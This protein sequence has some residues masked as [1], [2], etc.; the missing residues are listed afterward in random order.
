MAKEKIKITPE[1]LDKL[2]RDYTEFKT[3][4]AM[5][6]YPK[7]AIPSR[8]GSTTGAERIAEM[9]ALA[10]AYDAVQAAR[11][12]ELRMTTIAPSIE[13]IQREIAA[14]HLEALALKPSRKS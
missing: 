2:T 13:Q 11:G 9:R 4:L 1:R 14:D 10:D 8:G 5:V 12:S 7:E 3:F 6:A